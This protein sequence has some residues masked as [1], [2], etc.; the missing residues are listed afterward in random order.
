MEKI[1][2]SYDKAPSLILWN[3]SIFFAKEKPW[4]LSILLKKLHSERKPQLT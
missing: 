4:V 2:S 1:I 3:K